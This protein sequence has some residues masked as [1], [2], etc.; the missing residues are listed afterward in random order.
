M[1]RHTGQPN[2]KSGDLRALLLTASVIAT[3]AGA[4]LLALQ[5]PVAASA[6]TEPVML[7]EPVPAP[8]SSVL[9][10]PNQQQSIV[11]L[12]PIPQVAQPRLDPIVR[13]RSSR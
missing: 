2:R 11:E 10:Q 13:S 8:P 5:E 6:N 7:V 9:I 12:K 4:R 1:S 3:L